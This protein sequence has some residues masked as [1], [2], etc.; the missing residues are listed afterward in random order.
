MAYRYARDERQIG[1]KYR[2]ENSLPWRR[3]LLGKVLSAFRR[4][5]WTQL[6]SSEVFDSSTQIQG[7]PTISGCQAS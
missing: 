5:D 4:T 7:L 2:E 6:F 3:V 1:E